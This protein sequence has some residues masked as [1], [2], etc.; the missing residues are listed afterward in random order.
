MGSCGSLLIIQQSSNLLNHQSSPTWEQDS[1]LVMIFLFIVVKC[2]GKSRIK[3][4]KLRHHLYQKFFGKLT[5]KL[6]F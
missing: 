3:K 1:V 2:L 6:G 4:L 5:K